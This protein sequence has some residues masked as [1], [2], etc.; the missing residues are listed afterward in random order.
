VE[1][2]ASEQPLHRAEVPRDDAGEDQ[3]E[4]GRELSY[5]GE[6]RP[7]D[8]GGVPLE[9]ADACPVETRLVGAEQE[10]DREGIL[11][12]DSLELGGGAERQNGVAGADCPLEDRVWMRLGAIEH[13]FA[14]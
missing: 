9:P 14:G 13:M 11:K 8:L 3:L 10:A 6:G 2:P 12:V 5:V 7:V 4:P 1:L